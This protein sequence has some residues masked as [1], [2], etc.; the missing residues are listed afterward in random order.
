MPPPGR[1]DGGPRPCRGQG[2]A[3]PGRARPEGDAP[4]WRWE[5]ER[6]HLAI[7]G[8]PGSGRDALGAPHAGRL[9]VLV[10]AAPERGRATAAIL[11]VLAEAF[12]V[13]RARVALVAGET[14]PVKQ[15]VIT[16][17]G[18]L[19]GGVEPPGRPTGARGR[20]RR[21]D[22]SGGGI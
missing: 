7:L 16:A 13:P 19:A 18:R 21:R 15:V 22:G 12:D 9:R 3:M 6:L 1:P 14:S 17:P 11:A 8:R 4:F 20:R 2:A 5:G 10:R